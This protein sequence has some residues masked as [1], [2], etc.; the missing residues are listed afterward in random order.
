MYW[1]NI[2]ISYT[3]ARKC[4]VNMLH[5]LPIDFLNLP[6]FYL[7]IENVTDTLQ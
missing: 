1:K 4:A 7:G 2:G 5:K 6:G 3:S